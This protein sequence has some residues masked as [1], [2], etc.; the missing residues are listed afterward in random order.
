MFSDKVKSVRQSRG[1]AVSAR[2]AFP[3]PRVE[4][5]YAAVLE[6][7]RWL[8]LSIDRRAPV[9]SVALVEVVGE[10]FAALVVDTLAAQPRW[11][12]QGYR[13]QLSQLYDGMLGDDGQ[14]RGTLV[15]SAPNLVSSLT[16][17]WF[18][19]EVLALVIGFDPDD[20]D[21]PIM[22]AAVP[23]QDPDDCDPRIQAAA[24]PSQDPGGGP[25]GVTVDPSVVLQA[26][27]LADLSSGLSDAMQVQ[28]TNARGGIQG[29]LLV[30][31]NALL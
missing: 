30:P 4:H 25:P 16:P 1:E 13:S 19:R 21:P 28:I 12:V 23:S 31:T 14:D 22:I 24:V 3:L 2:I 18:R 20:C 5:S 10:R 8:A 26:Q 17:V 6:I 29:A 9:R 27:L 11:L 15:I 7:D